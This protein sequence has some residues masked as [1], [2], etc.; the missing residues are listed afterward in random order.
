[1]PF[2]N[3]CK[4]DSN[5]HQCNYPWFV[6]T[7]NM[8]VRTFSTDI[9]KKTEIIRKTQSQLKIANAGLVF[10][11]LHILC[12]GMSSFKKSFCPA[13][14][15]TSSGYGISSRHFVGHPILPWT[16]DSSASSQT[17]SC[18][19]NVFLSTSHAIYIYWLSF[20]L[21]LSLSFFLGSP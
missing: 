11:S 5:R 10:F 13:D 20:F 6:V 4:C 7:S 19:W 9:C 15:E 8:N 14:H 2:E 18:T 12:V 16:L 17:S 3:S 1:M 21:S